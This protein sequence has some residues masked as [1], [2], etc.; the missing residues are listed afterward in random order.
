MQ[1]FFLTRIENTIHL[2][3]NN[4]SSIEKYEIPNALNIQQT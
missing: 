3:L 1:H 4:M 2:I